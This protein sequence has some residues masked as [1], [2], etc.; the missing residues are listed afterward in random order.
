MSHSESIQ[1][2]RAPTSFPDAFPTARPPTAPRR[3]LW[4][5]LFER[6]VTIDLVAFRRL[7]LA[8]LALGLVLPLLHVRTLFPCPL[9]TLTGVPCP[10]CGMTTSVVALMHLHPGRALDANPIGLL[11]VAVALA[12]ILLRPRKVQIPIGL[13]VL[14][15]AASWL[16]ELHRFGILG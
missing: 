13:F 1:V 8:M 12:L 3:A 2:G 6:P 11:V 5:L 7:G 10:L 4:A 16:F 14:A 15:A 9:R